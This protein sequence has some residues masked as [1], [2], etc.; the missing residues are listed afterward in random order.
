MYLL[1]VTRSPSR[2]GRMIGEQC[3]GRA[4]ARKAPDRN[5]LDGTIALTH[6]ES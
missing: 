3:H 6:A 1:H 5:G 4:F 2:V